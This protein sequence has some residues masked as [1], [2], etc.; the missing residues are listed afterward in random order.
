VLLQLSRKSA[1]S[2]QVS[3]S[4]TLVY[5]PPVEPVQQ[6]ADAG[7]GHAWVAGHDDKRAVARSDGFGYAQ[8]GVASERDQPGHLGANRVRRVNARSVDAQEIRPVPR[9]DPER[10]VVLVALDRQSRVLETV[11]RQGRSPEAAKPNELLA[12]AKRCKC[13]D[14]DRL[15]PGNSHSRSMLL[16]SR[17]R[18]SSPSHSRPHVAC[19]GQLP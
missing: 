12:P 7:F 5:E 8:L 15:N 6:N 14:T 4:E 2:P 1:D 9:V 13:F 10:R 19:A 16:G 18:T 11:S 3:G 17:L